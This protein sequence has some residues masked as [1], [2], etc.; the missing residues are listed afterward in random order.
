MHRSRRQRLEVYRRD[1]SVCLIEITLRELKQLFNTL[2]P[3]PFHEK[4]L[5]H[6]AK[7]FIVVWARKYRR[8]DPLAL[9][10]L[11]QSANTAA[12]SR[13]VSNCLITGSSSV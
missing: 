1:G 3:A 11:S 7:E 10:Q 6:D 8:S 5:D 13:E 4:D 2:D 9:I 12:S